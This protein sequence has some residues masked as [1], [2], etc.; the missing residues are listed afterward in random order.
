MLY[1]ISNL[2]QFK[3]SFKKNWD[4]KNKNDKKHNTI[5]CNSQF[6]KVTQIEKKSMWNMI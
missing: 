1:L 2:V 3:I 6:W 5:M 4:K